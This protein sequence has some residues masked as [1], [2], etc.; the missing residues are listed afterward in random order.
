[1]KVPE[2][3]TVCVGAREY[4]AGDEIPDKHVPAS[5]KKAERAALVQPVSKAEPVEGKK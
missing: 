1:M 3:M 2:G 5:M 4:R